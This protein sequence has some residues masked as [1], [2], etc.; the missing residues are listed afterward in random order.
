MLKEVDFKSFYDIK[1]S[2]NRFKQFKC[3]IKHAIFDL[4][5]LLLK[6]NP[7]TSRSEIILVLIQLFQ[8][9][10]YAFEEKVYLPIITNT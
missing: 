9:A 8:L 6:Y 3:K 7:L 1:K 5:I 4:L 10:S 2:A